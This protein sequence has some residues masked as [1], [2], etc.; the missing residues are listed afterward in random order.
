MDHDAPEDRDPDGVVRAVFDRLP[1]LIVVIDGEGR[2]SLANQRLLDVMGYTLEGVVGTS[3]FDYVHP[4]DHDYMA[5]TWENRVANPGQTGILIDVRGKNA[6]GSWRAVEALGLSLLEDGA[7]NGMVM[8]MRDLSRKS[9]FGDAPRLRSMIDRTTDVVLLLNED[10]R[11]EFANR[12]LTSRYGLD[13]DDVVGLGFTDLLAAGDGERATEWFDDLLAAGDRADSRIRLSVAA[14]GQEHDV[15]WH[16]TNQLGDPLINGVILSGRDITE[17]VEME[18]RVRAQT[19]QL[20]HSARHDSLTGLFNRRAFVE[21]VEQHLDDRRAQPDP[22]DVIV[23]FCDLDRFK[24]VNDTH[25]HDVG[26]QVLEVVAARL[27][28]CLR[29]GDVVA[30]WGGDEFTIL[31][32][33]SAPEDVVD[34]LVSRLRVR[35]DEPIQCG[36]LVVDI[37]MTVGVSRARPP[38]RA[39]AT[40]SGPPTRRCTRRSWVDPEVRLRR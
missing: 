31:L 38:T 7:V 26:D 14:L 18:L 17:L 13:Q 16:G 24:A 10:A 3:I 15:E 22:G 36:A 2:I 37:G 6:D 11:I 20:M 39:P 9:R 5:R 21:A 35:F 40:C 12:R 33:R 25:G 19:E 28:G 8:T 32:G 23:L 29:D 34:A 1:E 4:D 30:R 27:R